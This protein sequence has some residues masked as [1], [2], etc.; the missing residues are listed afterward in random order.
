MELFSD[1]EIRIALQLFLAVLL[2]VTIGIERE[3]SGKEAGIRTYAL[4]ALGSALFTI[5]GVET[6]RQ[7]SIIGGISFDP[8]RIV[9]SIALGIGFIGAGIIIYRNS[10]VEGVTTATGVWVAGAIGLAVGLEFYG[11]AIFATLLAFF[12]LSGLHPLKRWVRE[13]KQE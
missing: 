4:V 8:S 13:K 7:F 2:G 10:H 5:V 1:L 12:V 11:I 3:V 9:N 6:F